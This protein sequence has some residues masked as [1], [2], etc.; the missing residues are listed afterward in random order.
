MKILVI[1]FGLL[2]SSI[3]SSAQSHTL[4]A[5]QYN[6]HRPGSQTASGSKINANKLKSGK[7]RWVAL[8]RDMLKIYPFDSIIRV[9]SKEHPELNGSWV[10]KDKMGPRHKKCIDFL[11]YKGQSR[12]GRTKVKIEK[13]G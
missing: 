10:V 2:I 11:I 3:T 4:S 6:L 9:E 5:T 8:S 13:I 7:I 12:L 1:S